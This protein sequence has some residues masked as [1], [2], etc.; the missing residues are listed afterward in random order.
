MTNH[1]KGELNHGL[2]RQLR[3]SYHAALFDR[4]IRVRGD[5]VP[6]MA[7]GASPASV[8][9]ARKMIG[10][11]GGEIQEGSVTAQGVGAM[12]GEITAEYL[13]YCFAK[14]AHIRPGDW[15]FSTLQ[16]NA[17][18]T[19]FSQYSHITQLNEIMDKHPEIKA[20]LGGDYLILPD[21][22]VSRRSIA[23]D[24]I[25][26]EEELLRDGDGCANRTALRNGN[27]SGD[28]E[29]LLASISLKWSLRS[30]R[31]QN[32]RTEALNLIR[33]RKGAT[34]RIMVVTFE[35][36]PARIASIAMGTG[37]ID[38]TYHVALDELLEAAADV[39]KNE[40][41]VEMLRTLTD[42]QRL[43]DISDLPFDL[44]S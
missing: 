15:N 37:D 27:I 4:C 38:C 31:A 20:S 28:P 8:E 11:L 18:I 1:A 3:Q 26:R 13:R 44:A 40:S 41:H 35:P 10:S 14:L 7:D 16:G 21:I 5:G 42:G 33:N 43:R 2:F 23:D 22:A 6:N 9:I 17:G 24:E 25:N 19:K 12:F 29:T 36:L 32:A 34:P 30:D 39:G